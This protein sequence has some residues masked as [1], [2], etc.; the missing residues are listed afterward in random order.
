MTQPLEVVGEFEE[1][2][3]RPKD[4]V[5]LQVVGSLISVVRRGFEYG[6]EEHRRDP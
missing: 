2:L 3:V 5:D 1:L 6:I 4:R